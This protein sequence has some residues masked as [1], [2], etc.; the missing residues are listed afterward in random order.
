MLDADDRLLDD[1]ELLLPLLA[2]EAEEADDLL[3]PLL[4]DDADKLDDER[5]LTLTEML[6]DE[7]SLEQHR[8]K[9][10]L[11]SKRPMITSVPS[12]M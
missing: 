1:D 3:L 10:H 2:D 7:L 11:P 5:L 4:D 8:S 12:W 9:Y 6:D